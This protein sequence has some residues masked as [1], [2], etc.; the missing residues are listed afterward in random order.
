MFK[1]REANGHVVTLERSGA[2]GMYTLTVRAGV[3]LIHKVR[4]DTGREAHAAFR[5]SPETIMTRY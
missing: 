2:R 3:T 5:L 4:F 1:T